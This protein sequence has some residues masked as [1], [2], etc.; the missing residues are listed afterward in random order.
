M[1]TLNEAVSTYDMDAANKR[2]SNLNYACERKDSAIKRLRSMLDLIEHTVVNVVGTDNGCPEWGDMRNVLR[3]VLKVS[4]EAL[5][6]SKH[7]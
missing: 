4:R 5:A 3:E 2:I 6:G 7:N 1:K